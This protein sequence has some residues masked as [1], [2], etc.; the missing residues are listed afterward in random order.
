MFKDPLIFNYIIMSLYGINT[1]QF[2]YRGFYSDA[3]YWVSAF[4]ITAA[5]TWGYGR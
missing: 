1:L 5:V 4:S 3:W 2:L